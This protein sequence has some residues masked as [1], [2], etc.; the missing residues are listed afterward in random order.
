[1]VTLGLIEIVGILIAPVLHVYVWSTLPRSFSESVRTEEGHKEI[2]P[3]GNT[4]TEP[5]AGL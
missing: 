5:K 3:A 1:V 4:L 2:L